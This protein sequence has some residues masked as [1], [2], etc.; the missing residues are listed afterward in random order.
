MAQHAIYVLS[1]DISSRIRIHC[2]L[3]KVLFSAFNLYPLNVPQFIPPGAT[4]GFYH[5]V[6][7]LMTIDF[8]QHGPIRIVGSKRCRNF[9]P[10]WKRYLPTW[11]NQL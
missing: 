10:S 2:Y 8:N 7:F 6:K 5:K 1:F 11:V 4:L 3:L 9:E